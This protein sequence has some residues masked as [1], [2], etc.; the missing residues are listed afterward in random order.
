VIDQIS[1]ETLQMDTEECNG[2]S[3]VRSVTVGHRGA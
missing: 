1:S 3:Y 2:S